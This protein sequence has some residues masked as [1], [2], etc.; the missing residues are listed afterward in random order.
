MNHPVELSRLQ[1]VGERFRAWYRC[2]RCQCEFTQG[3]VA[4]LRSICGRCGKS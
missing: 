4:H 3:G 2:F 1:L